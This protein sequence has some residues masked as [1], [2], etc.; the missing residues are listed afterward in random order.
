[1]STFAMLLVVAALF[2]IVSAC[3]GPPSVGQAFSPSAA[4]GPP[5][6]V[7]PPSSQPN[8]MAVVIGPAGLHAR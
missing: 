5:P 7:G 1:M 6:D 2:L 3:E 8:P 4:G